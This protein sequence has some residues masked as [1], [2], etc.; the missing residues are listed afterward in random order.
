MLETHYSK[1]KEIHWNIYMFV[2]IILMYLHVCIFK[3]DSV[4]KH[5]F[6]AIESRS[7]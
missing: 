4:I 6:E 7:L 5:Q 3:I 1:N 2:H